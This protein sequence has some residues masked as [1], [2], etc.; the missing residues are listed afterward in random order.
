M[1]RNA[2]LGTQNSD[3]PEG[4]TPGLESQKG[5]LSERLT[6][7]LEDVLEG[8]APNAG[9][10]CGYCYHL[11]PAPEE[12]P[13][14]CPHCG[15]SLDEWQPVT[16]VPEEVFAMYQAQ[17]SREAWL[18][19]GLAWSGLTAGVVLGLLPLAFFGVSWWT[20]V[21]FFGLMMLFYIGSANL[22]NSVGD[23]VGYRWGQAALRKRWEAFVRARESAPSSPSSA[24]S[25]G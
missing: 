18:V 8:R 15:R 13:E 14:I 21:A 17:R 16:R 5:V 7:L 10:F 6:G 19:R 9:R 25:G 12:S 2:G 1:S 23:A 24:S 11:L 20:V 4:A 3:S 22:A